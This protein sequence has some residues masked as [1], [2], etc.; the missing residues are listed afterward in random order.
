MEKC[1]N[2]CRQI[3]ILKCKYCSCSFCCRCI[4]IDIHSCVSSSA[5]IMELK[6]QL[7]NTL[8]TH[9]VIR[10]GIDDT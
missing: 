8:G 3:G 2:S 1:G 10:H 5:K 6:N 9:K 7:K 4:Q